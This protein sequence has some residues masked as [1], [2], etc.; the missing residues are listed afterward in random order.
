M[1]SDNVPSSENAPALDSLPLVD[2]SKSVFDKIG[3]STT[4]LVNSVRR[5]HG[6]Y[7]MCGIFLG[8]TKPSF[9]WVLLGLSSCIPT[10]M[11]LKHPEW[12]MR[13]KDEKMEHLL[14]LLL[15]VAASEVFAL[16]CFGN[17]LGFKLSG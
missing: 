14:L 3:S 12:V 9:G 8:V 6:E 5:Y 7:F 13:F 4:E 2:N 1:S 15:L 10:L 16:H 11:I 17:S